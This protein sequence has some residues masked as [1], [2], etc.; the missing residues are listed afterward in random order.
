MMGI[1]PVAQKLALHSHFSKAM[2]NTEITIR[3]IE[4]L[5]ARAA[6]VCFL[7]RTAVSI[8]ALVYCQNNLQ[9]FTEP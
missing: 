2:C 3:G 5:C 6:T 8:L 1:L 4:M 9:S 7:E